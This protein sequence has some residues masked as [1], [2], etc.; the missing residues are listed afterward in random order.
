MATGKPN[1]AGKV[2]SA[3]WRE[4]QGTLQQFFTN[5][6]PIFLVITVIASVLDWLGSSP[7]WRDG[8]AGDRRDRVFDAVG[9]GRKLVIV[10][11]AVWPETRFLHERIQDIWPASAQKPGFCIDV[12]QGKST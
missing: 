10:V 4:T 11:S 12:L 5:A 6:I 2:R 8:S 3:I 1:L 7:R 9:L